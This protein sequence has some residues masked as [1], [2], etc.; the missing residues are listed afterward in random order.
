MH[1]GVGDGHI[2][3]LLC[4]HVPVYSSQSVV[5]PVLTF[6][7]CFCVWISLAKMANYEREDKSTVSQFLSSTN[8]MAL[9]QILKENPKLVSLF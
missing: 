1:I 2:Y 4:L 9:K 8:F 6:V 3:F 7:R 5:S